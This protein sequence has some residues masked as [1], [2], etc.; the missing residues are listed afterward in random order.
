M[1]NLFECA[2]VNIAANNSIL[3]KNNNK[4]LYKG[5]KFKDNMI[6]EMSHQQLMMIQRK[7]DTISKICKPYHTCTQDIKEYIKRMNLNVL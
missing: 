7:K 1:L 5:I 2:N 6:N 4:L 3:E